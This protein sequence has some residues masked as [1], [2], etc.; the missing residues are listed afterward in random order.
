MQSWDPTAIRQ[1]KKSKEVRLALSADGMNLPTG[2]PKDSTKRLQKAAGS[3]LNIKN[4]QPSHTKQ[5][6]ACG[7]KNL[8]RYVPFTIAEK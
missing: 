5:I 2:E 4:Q 3:K 1:E 6:C 7:K 8:V